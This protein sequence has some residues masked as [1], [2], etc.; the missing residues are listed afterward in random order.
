MTTV[1]H[2]SITADVLQIILMMTI[3]RGTVRGRPNDRILYVYQGGI[4][5]VEE[6]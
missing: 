1:H 5:S 6:R 3:R 4:L 2:W